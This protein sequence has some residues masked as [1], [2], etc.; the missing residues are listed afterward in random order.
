MLI[1]AY[2][3]HRMC[4]PVSSTAHS[5]LRAWDPR[6]R[7]A[8]G[9]I[10]LDNSRLRYVLPFCADPEAERGA[11]SRRPARLW[12]GMAKG[13]LQ[14]ILHL[15]LHLPPRPLFSLGGRVI[16]R[17]DGG[18][19]SRCPYLNCE[20]RV[21]GLARRGLVSPLRVVLDWGD[22][23]KAVERVRWPVPE[24]RFSVQ[25]RVDFSGPGWVS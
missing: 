15:H 16:S 23:M 4:W 22:C 17:A 12:H 1:M 2:I 7:D 14:P 21:A 9:G 20:A 5:R 8:D 24:L 19:L 25:G 6:S 10:D 13:G 3:I 18:V 11:D